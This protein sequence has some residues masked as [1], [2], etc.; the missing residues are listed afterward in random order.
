MAVLGNCLPFLLISW[1][2]QSIDSGVAGIL[3]AAGPL[4]VM[5]LAHWM[6]PDERLT[7]TAAVGFLCGF[8]GVVVLIGP[9]A[10]A[11]LS[12]RLTE[13]TLG[14]LAVLARLAPKHDPAVTAAA[15]LF[16]STG[17]MLP[18]AA[19]QLTPDPVGF[20]AL[21]VF[22]IAMLGFAC[23]GLAALLY[24]YVVSVAG[25]RFLSLINYLAPVWTVLIGVLWLGERLPARAYL[26]LLMV[27]IGVLLSQRR[28]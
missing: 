1:G 12:A 22:A 25:A 23:T 15:V 26:A 8:A 16:C 13:S 14:H 6:L 27:L 19:H 2:Q 10:L 21:V 20:S 9:D 11:A 5:L 24:F 17:I 4:M 18:I 7:A 28:S 3:A